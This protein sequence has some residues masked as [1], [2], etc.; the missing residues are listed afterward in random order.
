MNREAYALFGL[1]YYNSEVLHRELCQIHALQSVPESLSS[2]PRNRFEE[3]LAQSYSLT[4]GRVINELKNDFLKYFKDE[5]EEAIERRNFLAHYFWW[6]KCH[7]FFDK[8]NLTGVLGEL[9]EHSDFFADLESKVTEYSRELKESSPDYE[10]AIQKALQ[11]IIE[12]KAL[13]PLPRKTE[14][15]EKLRKLK[16]EQ[17]I[18]R[19][20]E[21]D[22]PSGGKPLIFETQAHYC[23]RKNMKV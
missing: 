19:V 17:V 14:L 20:W 11:N 16:E 21:Y 5:L 8:E 18:V 23:P 1:A 3:I 13:K 15:K 6:E 9:Q 10:E 4:L 22:L 12:G 7:L 2:I